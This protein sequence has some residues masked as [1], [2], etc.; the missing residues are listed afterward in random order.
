MRGKKEKGGGGKCRGKRRTYQGAKKEMKKIP[1]REK[2]FW[3]AI[4]R[5]EE[6]RQE[7]SHNSNTNFSRVEIRIQYLTII[8]IMV[9]FSNIETEILYFLL[10]SPISKVTKL[11]K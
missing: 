11:I 1:K 5:N 10:Y 7:K 3:R 6:K 8:I 4:R 9:I 2:C